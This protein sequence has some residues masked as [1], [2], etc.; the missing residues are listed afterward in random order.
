M[1]HG[2]RKGSGEG[3]RGEGR[4]P[5]PFTHLASEPGAERT[6]PA[7][8]AAE[9]V[10]A[11]GAPLVAGRFEVRGPLGPTGAGAEGRVYRVRDHGR[12]GVESAL[13]ILPAEASK[14]DAA[15]EHLGELIE[16]ARELD[17]ESLV[18]PRAFGRTEL[19]LLF[20]SSDLVEGETLRELTERRGA[21]HPHH[22]IEIG[23]QILLA[24]EYGHA[25]GFVHGRLDPTKVMLARRVPWS[26]DE[27][28]G[29]GV[30][31]LE[32]GFAHAAPPTHTP[33]LA[34]EVRR[35]ERADERADVY[36]VGALL[37]ELLTGNRPPDEARLDD[38]GAPDLASGLDRLTP[39][40]RAGLVRALQPDPAVRYQNALRL[41]LALEEVRNDDR[42]ARTRRGTRRA[43]WVATALLVALSGVLGMWW[44]EHGRVQAAEEAV[45]SAR[46]D[47]E[48]LRRATPAAGAV[49]EDVA[50]EL[51]QL[52]EQLAAAQRESASW[53]TLAEAQEK[54]VGEI[55]DE[56]DAQRERAEGL[57]SQL[58]AALERLRA[59]EAADP[60]GTPPPDEV[61]SLLEELGA[62]RTERARARWTIAP[63]DLP[64]REFLG[65]LASGAVAVDGGPD[66]LPAA[67]AALASAR[68][69]LADVTAE[70]GS[71]A[72]RA[73]EVLETLEDRLTAAVRAREAGWDALFA[74][75][76]ERTPAEVRAA[77]RGLVGDRVGEFVSRYARYVASACVIDGALD[78]GALERLDHLDAWSAEVADD[79]ALAQTAYGRSLVR[80]AAARRFYRG[81][82][83][84]LAA[85]GP[86][87][88]GAAEHWSTE[89]ALRA[90]MLT[91]TAG[92]PGP[93]GARF[94]YRA[95][96]PEGRVSWQEVRVAADAERPA[97]A[98]RSVVLEQRF[99][100]AR[101]EPVGEQRLHAV[102]RGRAWRIAEW[103]AAPVLDLGG[104]PASFV[105]ADYAPQRALHVPARMP[106][107]AEELAAFA[108]RHMA[109]SWPTLVVSDGPAHRWY[110]PVLGLVR[111]E[112]PGRILRELVYAELPE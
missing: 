83:V 79:A 48:E 1:E 56:R 6:E 95:E 25:R 24:M 84:P 104:P 52:A 98:T 82:D 100:D 93:V 74:A 5:L 13:K 14:G 21:L 78:L 92:W 70:L 53:K 8:G 69:T 43:R 81:E 106:F 47:L 109:G 3:R 67:R 46:D 64:A 30:R 65:A 26:P 88:V 90:A 96:T 105:V 7:A 110:S 32:F 9:P 63:S 39:A 112:E 55:G 11:T 16:Q 50:L 2:A 75:R 41:R 33:Y 58:G 61:A 68:A 94:L 59:R 99:F 86:P 102:L 108:K 40:L 91:E 10:P 71:N 51:E 42:E 18:R 72:E 107:D 34:P 44:S 101:G 29:V 19:G 12:G 23:R 97:G 54:R 36:S 45:Q 89:L 31:L 103:G 28:F 20:V 22:A 73:R 77:A 15:A 85:L 62:G 4:E 66:E 57:A 60:S 27:P 38:S 76:P 37:F 111:H 49:P 35:G 80:F 87:S 17:H